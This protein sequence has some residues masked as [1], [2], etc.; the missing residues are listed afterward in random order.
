MYVRIRKQPMV[1]KNYLSVNRLL[2]EY[3][4]EANLAF[5]FDMM[6]REH[7]NVMTAR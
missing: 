7:C 6:G 1:Q 3:V 2:H 5:T 4:C